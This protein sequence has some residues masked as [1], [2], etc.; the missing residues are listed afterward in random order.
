MDSDHLL[1]GIDVLINRVNN[2]D[3]I[4]AKGL[5]DTDFPDRVIASLHNHLG[6]IKHFVGDISAAFNATDQFLAIKAAERELD[7][8]S[9]DLLELHQNSLLN[10]YQY[11]KLAETSHELDEQF[12]RATDPEYM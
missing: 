5:K 11:Q 6:N 2:I 10:D 1:A 8:A 7:E 12:R 3:S 4:S 9:N